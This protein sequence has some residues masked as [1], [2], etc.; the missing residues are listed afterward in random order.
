MS[1]MDAP[2]RLAKAAR[3]MPYF[4]S[5]LVTCEKAALNVPPP[6]VNGLAVSRK[7]LSHFSRVV[8]IGFELASCFDLLWVGT[9]LSI[10]G[11]SVCAQENPLNTPA[12]S[13]TKK[14]AAPGVV[15]RIL[16]TIPRCSE[17]TIGE[18]RP[19]DD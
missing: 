1:A 3:L 4:G 8:R 18:P 17:T 9:E 15:Y 7:K 19:L 10:A 14:K 16:D 6:K 11:G 13:K 2:K 5:V 12:S